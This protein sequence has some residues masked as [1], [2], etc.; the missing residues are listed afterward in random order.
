MID[1]NVGLGLMG[2]FN[3]GEISE[4]EMEI[5]MEMFADNVL[6]VEIKKLN[7]R[8]KCCKCGKRPEKVYWGDHKI[9]YQCQEC[10]SKVYVGNIKSGDTMLSPAIVEVLEQW[11]KDNPIRKRRV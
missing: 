5:N 9:M 2:K 7:G 3:S 8:N 6:E 10:K 1:V 11:N 4:K